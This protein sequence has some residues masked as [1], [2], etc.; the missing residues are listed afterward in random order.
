[1]WLTTSFA[2]CASAKSR[3]CNLR[4]GRAQ[5]R[6]LPRGQP[7]SS[8][9]FTER[10]KFWKPGSQPLFCIPSPDPHHLRP[11]SLFGSRSRK[12]PNCRRKKPK[13]SPVSEVFPK[14]WR[15]EPKF[16][17]RGGVNEWNLRKEPKL[18]IDLN[19]WRGR[20]ASAGNLRKVLKCWTV[21]IVGSGRLLGQGRRR[22]D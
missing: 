1:M 22:R 18:G 8:A 4:S 11:P 19:L 15:T 6:R 16:P 3:A 13:L 9:P 21:R 17:G 5:L 20:W 12:D 7:F 2:T 10:D 14:Q